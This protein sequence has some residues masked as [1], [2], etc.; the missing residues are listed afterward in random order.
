MGIVTESAENLFNMR[1]L[2]D[3]QA[4]LVSYL[5]FSSNKIRV[6]D[7]WV[8]LFRLSGGYVH[9]LHAVV[10]GSLYVYPSF[11]L[12]ESPEYVSTKEEINDMTIRDNTHLLPGQRY[13]KTK[14]STW[15]VSNDQAKNNWRTSAVT[16]GPYIQIS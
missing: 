12:N 14:T 6:F 16:F 8:V 9:N 4:K 10:R 1:E 11:I 2:T 7:I 13:M 3:F 15:V 5:K